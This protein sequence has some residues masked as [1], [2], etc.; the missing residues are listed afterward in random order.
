M[1]KLPVPGGC[2]ALG[3]SVAQIAQDPLLPMG[4]LMI[5]YQCHSCAN[6]EIPNGNTVLE[7]GCTILVVTRPESVHL[8]IDFLGIQVSHLPTREVSLQLVDVGLHQIF[9]NDPLAEGIPH[10]SLF[11]WQQLASNGIESAAISARC[12]SGGIAV[13]RT[14]RY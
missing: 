3:G 9:W 2:Y 13:Q 6:L 1:L 4:S 12:N 8:M 5:G 10:G 11:C 7:A 14:C